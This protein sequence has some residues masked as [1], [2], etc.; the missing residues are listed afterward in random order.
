MNKVQNKALYSNLSNYTMENV[1]SDI[2][3][4]TLAEVSTDQLK[5]A[6]T[7]NKFGGLC[8]KGDLHEKAILHFTKALEAL[9][10]VVFTNAYQNLGNVYAQKNKV[11][12]AI[13]FYEKVINASPFNPDNADK[14]LDP[15]IQNKLINSKEAYIDAFTNLGKI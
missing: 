5:S 12:D 7:H 9:G 6:I 14:I 3:S 4:Y 2:L 15:N 11:H 10:N 8:F 13:K 1:S